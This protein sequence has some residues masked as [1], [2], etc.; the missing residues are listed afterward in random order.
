ML[1]EMDERER[2]RLRQKAFEEDEAHWRRIALPMPR[3]RARIPYRDEFTGDEIDRLLRS[4]LPGDM[5]DKWIALRNDAT[6]D[7]HRSWTGF[8]I[9]SV[10]LGPLEVEHDELYGR[11]IEAWANR[12][13]EQ[14]KTIGDA[15]DAELVRWL[16]RG[17]MLGQEGVAYPVDPTLTGDDALLAAW[18]GGGQAAFPGAAE[19]LHPESTTGPES[20]ASS[21]SAGPPDADGA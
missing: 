6:L 17:L 18:A 1:V 15:Y 20:D 7:F 21:E 14:W 19:I 8:H 4:V 10:V 3:A 16:M 9:F 2:E 12:D 5:A 11:V 13:P